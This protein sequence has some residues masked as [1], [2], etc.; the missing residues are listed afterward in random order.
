MSKTK[1]LSLE[2]KHARTGFLFILPWFIGFLWF[3]GKG[4]FQAI[5]F[6]LSKME[7]LGSGGYTLKFVG[8]SNFKFSL[9]EDPE[10]N[11]I[12][13]SSIKDVV[14]D[15]PLIIFFSLFIAMLCNKKFKGRTLVRAILFLPIIL[16]TGAINDALEVART[17][18]SGGVAA[19]SSEVALGSA[20]DINN[21]VLMMENLGF[22][23]A[24][25]DY[26]LQAISRIFEIVQASGVQI[27]LFIAALQS[28][29]EAL[30]EVAKIE[31]ATT[32]ETFWKVTFPMVSPI[33][34]T[35]VV[36]TIVDS[37]VDSEVVEKA[38]EMAFTDFNW[39][40]SVAMSLISSAVICLILVIVSKL[41]SKKV[42]YYN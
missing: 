30:Y 10:F 17:A 27:I 3:Y 40:A 5:R 39:G 13:V 28:V 16:N 26:L 4:L 32:Y 8:L 6:S 25:L 23:V 20:F 41:I 29:P 24:V 14:I 42:F 38:Y 37:F 12:L 2:K 9:L 21:L 15:V 34:L 33:I 36:Y 19:S 22:P 7:M 1:K 35:N 11:Q 31:G 18:I